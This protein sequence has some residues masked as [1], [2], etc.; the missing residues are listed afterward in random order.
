M[1]VHA[2]CRSSQPPKNLRRNPDGAAHA[3]LGVE[4][5]RAA[6]LERWPD[7][8]VWVDAARSGRTGRRPALRAMLDALQPGDV[9]AVVRLDRLARDTRLA[10][11]L[12]LEIETT[13]GAR[14]VSLAGEGTSEA[15]PPDPVAT[16]NRRVA[17]AVAELQAHQAAA[18]TTAAFKVKRER[19]LATSGQ[20]PFGFRIVDGRLD[21]D[22][23]EQTVVDAVRQFTRGRP[24]AVTGPELARYLNARGHVNREGRPW[25]RVTALSLA[26]RLAQQTPMGAAS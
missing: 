14:I 11:A 2:Y 5:Q 16:F 22:P 25:S 10:M 6:L 4:S 9:V 17:A 7:A 19:G 24:D 21:P 3:P 15:G 1:A 8:T 18:A 20:P 23:V 12:E 26:R 13:R